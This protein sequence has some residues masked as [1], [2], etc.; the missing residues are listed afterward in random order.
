M[1]SIV[2]V[3]YYYGLPVAWFEDKLNSVN[4]LFN[5]EDFTYEINGNNIETDVGKYY[6]F[7]D[8][9]YTSVSYLLLEVLKNKVFVGSTLSINGDEVKNNSSLPFI[10]F[11]YLLKQ[12]S[13]Y[14]TLQNCNI[15]NVE[16]NIRVGS[17]LVKGEDYTS[18]NDFDILEKENYGKKETYTKY[19]PYKN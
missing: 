2:R 14:L 10:P 18:V 4:T 5:V 12:D 11:K 19:Y 6:L 3:R 1:R 15:E 7:E 16:G 8:L 9:V 17:T 13:K